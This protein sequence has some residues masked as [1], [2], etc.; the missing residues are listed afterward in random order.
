[1]RHS[2]FLRT[3]GLIALLLT[4]SLL[5]WL[6]LLHHAQRGPEAARFATEAAS[7]VNLTRAGLMSASEAERSLLLD[8]LDQDENIRVLAVT[9]QDRVSLWPSDR[10]PH[11]LAIELQQRIP[12]VQ[13]AREV[14]GVEGV[15][16]K[17]DIDA[18]PY[19]LMLGEDRLQR[20]QS[21]LV[22]GGWLLAALALS[23]VGA[24]GISARVQRPLFR[25]GQRLR[26]VAAGEAVALLPESG[27]RELVRVH[28]QFNQMARELARLEQDRAIALAGISHDLRTPLAR[29]RLEL[30]MAPLD[31]PV[32]R[33]LED[34]LALIDQRIGQFIEFARPAPGGPWTPI[35]LP[36]LIPDILASLALPEGACAPDYQL[37]LPAGLHWSGPRASLERILDN[38]VLNAL[39]HGRDAQGRVE[40]E[41]SAHREG[42]AVVL[43]VRDH[44]PG[45]PATD[46]ERLMRP[47]ERGNSA[48]SGA[49]GS[50][51]GLA[52]VRQIARRHGGDLRLSLPGDGGLRL[53]VWL[54]DGPPPYADPTWTPSAIDR[55][56]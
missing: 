12:G 49:A 40:L 38:L 2:L 25:L 31:P 5:T 9:S 51:L 56:N 45:V 16:L 4:A 54:Q 28:R 37:K 43:T 53:Q 36:T 21:G 14:N 13:L 15:W 27:P 55:I 46:L 26:A 35:D 10:R 20:H 19:W 50:G 52:I 42:P 24:L 8:M 22:L 47:F 18:E 11:N 33:A 39:H 34:D 23:C 6:G 30:E 17:F 1:M 7:L 48:R 41:L 32:R 29:V 3:F 44:G